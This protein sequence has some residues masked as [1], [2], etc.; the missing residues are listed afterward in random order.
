MISLKYT[1]SK[2]FKGKI[3]I[4]L[5]YLFFLFTFHNSF[6][7]T[8]SLI[9]FNDLHFKNDFEKNAFLRY[10]ETKDAIEVFD[11]LFNSYNSSKVGNK[12]EALKKIENCVS[13]LNGEISGKS[14]IKKVKITYDYVHKQFLKVY[15]LKNSFI[16]IFES[17]EYNCVSASALY[18]IV[19]NKFSIPYQ[20]RETPEHIYLV[21]YPNSS[22]ILIETTA[23]NKGY[24][25]FNNNFVTSFVTNLYESKT[26]SKEER[27]STSASDLFNKY[28]YTSESVSLLELSSSQY[29]NFAIYSIDENDIKNAYQE[30]KKAC[31]LFQ[32]ESNKYILKS[33]LASL[34]NKSGYDDPENIEIL[35]ILCR[36]NNLKDLEISNTFI[37]NEFLKIIQTQLIKNSDY[38]SFE[39]SYLKIIKELKDSILKNEIGFDYHYELARLGYLSSKSQEYEIEHLSKAYSLNPMNANLRSMILATF[40][41]TIQKLNDSKSIM[42]LVDSY[43]KHFS[44][45]KNENSFLSVKSNCILDMAYQSFFLNNSS[46]GDALIREFEELVKMNGN[47]SPAA[48][49]VEKAYSKAASEYYRKGNIPKAKQ[50]LKTGLIYAPNSFG[51][52]QRLNQFD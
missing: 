33:T 23:P 39:K 49:F 29:S 45:L 15:K 9:K 25:Q 16:D 51:L 3:S 46:K 38:T 1:F 11:L 12:T 36:F 28:Y 21:A 13:Y 30:I 27:D 52:Q 40:G 24:Y 17:G 42:E 5:I 6:S 2:F 26:I 20:I 37:T 35:A 22:K 43:S 31:F 32:N 48:G 19:F 47:V 41:Q 34:I 10:R 44:F 8:D 50:L 7:Q 18:A 4:S 14:E